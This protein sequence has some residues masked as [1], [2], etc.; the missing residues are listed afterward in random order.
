VYIKEYRTEWGGSCPQ[1]TI[2]P[3]AEAPAPPD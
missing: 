3:E 1:G 2:S